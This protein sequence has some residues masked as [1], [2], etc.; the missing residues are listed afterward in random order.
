MNDAAI[1]IHMLIHNNS[2]VVHVRE[3]HPGHSFMSTFLSSQALLDSF[4][5]LG[6]VP[7]RTAHNP[8]SRRKNDHVQGEQ[9]LPFS[10]LKFHVVT[11]L[12]HA[13]LGMT[14]AEQQAFEDLFCQVCL[15]PF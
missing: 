13:F 8:R 3:Q 14:Q 9:G 1:N 12:S 11:Q 10:L 4:A 5:L 6:S 7:L 15:Y 2:R